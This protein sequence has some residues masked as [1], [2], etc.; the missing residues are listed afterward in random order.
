MLVGVYICVPMLQSEGSPPEWS[1][2]IIMSSLCLSAHAQAKAY[3]S[4]FV[5]LYV[6]VCY[7]DSS[8]MRAIQVLKYAQ[9]SNV[10]L[11]LIC[12]IFEI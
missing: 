12:Q 8:S 2:S 1:N 6:S 3:G 10:F 11:D 4:L 9:M 5:C 7:R